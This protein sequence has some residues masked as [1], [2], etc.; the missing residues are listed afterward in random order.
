M[1]VPREDVYGGCLWQMGRAI[2]LSDSKF[3]QTVG[4]GGVCH[5]EYQCSANQGSWNR[6]LEQPKVSIGAGFHLICFIE[7]QCS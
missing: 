5:I 1:L 7:Y 6:V 2:L 3:T 4:F